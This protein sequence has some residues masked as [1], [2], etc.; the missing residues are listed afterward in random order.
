[1]DKDINLVEEIKN[2]ISEYYDPAEKEPVIKAKKQVLY[3]KNF[4][5]ALGRYLPQ[6]LVKKISIE[7][8]K[9][10][11]D[12]ERR[13]VTIL[14]ADLTGFTAMSE[15]MD[16]EDVVQVVNEYFTRMLNVVFKYGGAI[17]KFMGDAILVVFGALETH[18][19]DAIRATLAGIEMQ[20][21]MV[22][23]NNEGNLP[24]PLSMS[25]GINTGPVVAVNV[26]TI[27]RMEFTIMGDNV[28]L[29]SRLES[30][31]EPGQVIIS[32]STYQKVKKH[33]KVKKLS[34]VR[35][36]GKKKPVLIYLAEK[37]KIREKPKKIL[38]LK[39]RTKLIGR[40]EELNI[41]T[42]TI[43]T[44]KKGERKI[45]S[46]IGE[47]GT[48]KTRLLVETDTI[49]ANGGFTILRGDSYSYTSN[50]AY[51]PFKQILTRLFNISEKDSD[52]E[53]RKK[54]G[55]FLSSKGLGEME[56]VF[57]PTLLD[58]ETEETMSIPPEIKKK[59]IFESVRNLFAVL[60]QTPLCLK[61]EDLHWSDR[62]SIELLTFL[63][64]EISN[65]PFIFF[66]TF[67]PE[68][69]FPL[70]AEDFATNIHL[71]N[72]QK[73]LTAQ[74]LR[75]IFEDREPS[76][77]ITELVFKHTKGNPLYI[78]ALA[79][80]LAKRRLLKKKEVKVEL[81]KSPDEIRVPETINS[82]VMERVDRM[83]EMDQR[84][85]RMASIVGQIFT[86][87]DLVYLLQKEQEEIIANLESLEHFEGE[88]SSIKEGENHEYRF[89]T[90]TVREVIY[91]SMLK[92]T[93]SSLHKRYGDWIL[94]RN[95]KNP[96]PVFEILAYHFVNGGDVENGILFS[97]LSG[98]KARNYFANEAGIKF[99]N[100]AL[101]LL[102]KTEASGEK[103]K[104]KLEIFRR[105][106][107][108]LMMIGD[109]K[110]ALLN[111]KKSLRL[112]NKL[113]SEKDRIMSLLNIGILYDR[114][115]VAKKPIRYYRRA[116]NSAKVIGLFPLIAMAENNL[117]IY[118]KKTGK[119]KKA[120]TA[121]NHSLKINRNIKNQ[122]NEAVAIQNI[123]EVN[124]LL[125]FPEKA[126]ANYETAMKMFKEMNLNER[127]PPLCMSIS[128]IHT[129]K[130]DQE[131]AKSY[132]DKALN[133]SR[134]V[135]DMK[136]EKDSLGNLGNILF[137]MNQPTR[138]I[139]LYN[140]ALSMA[141]K[142]NDLEHQ[143][144]L[145]INIGEVFHNVGDFENAVEYHS[146]AKELAEVIG[147]SIGMLEATRWLGMD[148]YYMDNLKNTLEQ[149]QKVREKSN[150]IK[151]RKHSF[152]SDALIGLLDKNINK[153]KREEGFRRA[154]DIS[155]QIGDVDMAI[156]LFREAARVSV[157][158]E[159]FQS[160]F[161]NAS[162]LKKLSEQLGYMRERAWALYLIAI[163]NKELKNEGWQ[164][165]IEEAKALAGEIND[166]YLGS[167]INTFYESN[168]A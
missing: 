93:R 123:G 166:N 140:Q 48:G 156:T 32:H 40:K 2:A 13:T 163:C 26:G 35:V 152:Y 68:F 83:D 141:E 104:T 81:R 149:L 85:L 103:E 95:E 75:E 126:L 158:N 160:A 11:V 98:E 134:E 76:S 15:T 3:L 60:A 79:K 106:G 20:R 135:G 112:A 5:E 36:K 69:A 67:R 143:M 150:E 116:K 130:G 27:E 154:L 42:E 4:I 100:D 74:Y 167:V 53:K 90:P 137:R 109:T 59:Y 96:K 37:Q 29:A 84:V 49:L 9:I 105:Q 82:I 72:L 55:T 58:L 61:F 38:S 119:F 77:E 47:S 8:E 65:R 62:L 1:M 128:I 142:M 24:V 114:M 43:E 45:V 87:E 21:E 151:D 138:A 145:F 146:K 33:I 10:K 86:L 102:K 155:R 31:A 54:I 99:F 25:I 101:R 120:L 46:I 144:A 71:K 117:G 88:I 91:N 41:I 57:I 118:Y 63:S 161:N 164:S 147:G 168:Q 6:R 19:D 22:K 17:D 34:S 39:T 51:Y 139:E 14:F 70:I 132:A 129:I 12:G 121:F 159:D 56:A 73:E 7:P 127:I 44:V 153:E 64:H 110:Q 115:G 94:K 92:R 108:F 78:E 133:L 162:M 165:Q 136:T 97:K 148:Y 111:Q 131:K 157:K 50:I 113:G 122:V 30:V 28:N 80:N 125:G 66:G 16:P 89:N 124:Y 52:E 107:Y 18:E 23:F